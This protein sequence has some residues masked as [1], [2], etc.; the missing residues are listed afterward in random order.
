MS[1]RAAVLIATVLSALPG[2]CRSAAAQDLAI[3]DQRGLR[4]HVFLT[5]AARMT[6]LEALRGAGRR[7]A[8][9]GCRQLFED[10]TDR[11]GRPLTLNLEATAQ[12]AGDVLAGLYF[13]DGDDTIRCRTDRVVVAFT[14]PGSRVIHVCGR[15]F[16]QF[17]VKTRGGEILLIHEL[18]HALG[19][20]ENPP[21]S[22]RITDAVINR[23]G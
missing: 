6:V 16:L 2:V 18:L 12:S 7:L 19:L 9:P 4:Y 17:A 1:K 13:V 8:K 10:F 23:C 15:Q 5:G 3:A 14:H 22:E 21:T 20:G 11:T